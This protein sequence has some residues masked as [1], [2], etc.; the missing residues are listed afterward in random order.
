MLCQKISALPENWFWRNFLEHHWFTV[1]CKGTKIQCFSMF[2]YEWSQVTDAPKIWITFYFK[3]HLY[4]LSFGIELCSFSLFLI[5]SI[6]L[7]LIKNTNL[8]KLLWYFISSSSLKTDQSIKQY[9][10][11]ICQFYL[12]KWFIFYFG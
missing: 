6:F 7:I 3:V 12:K 4:I 8:F 5:F 11:N 9:F 1:Y 10:K 2:V